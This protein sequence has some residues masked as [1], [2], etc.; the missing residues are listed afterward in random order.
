MRTIDADALKELY[1]PYDGCGFDETYSVPIGVILQNIDDMPTVPQWISV[2]DRLPEMSG[3]YLCA[4]AY[5]GAE[6]YVSKVIWFWGV[7]TGDTPGW[8]IVDGFGEVGYWCELPKLP[9]RSEE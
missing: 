1:M 3:A 2:K 9:E 4:F 7:D 6:K 5:I 8:M